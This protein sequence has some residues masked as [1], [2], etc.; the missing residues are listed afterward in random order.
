MQFFSDRTQID[1]HL[2]YFEDDLNYIAD[3]LH[4]ITDGLP[5][6]TDV[7]VI[8][9]MVCDLSHMFA[10]ISVRKCRINILRC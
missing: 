6:V 10:I 9:Q 5:Y 1:H 2:Q 7:R 8:L 3:G 4:Y